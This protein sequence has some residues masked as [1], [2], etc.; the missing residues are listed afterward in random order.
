MGLLERFRRARPAAP[1]VTPE[2]SVHHAEPS[3]AEPAPAEPAPAEPPRVVLPPD[4]A[5]TMLLPVVRDL[6]EPPPALAERRGRH[7][8]PVLLP[9]TGP[10]PVAGPE[11][12]AAPAPT[13]PAPTEPAPPPSSGPGFAVVAVETT[14]LSPTWDRV[15]EVAVVRCDPSGAVEDAW[16]T[17]LDPGRRSAGTARRTGLRGD[18]LRGAPVFADVLGELADRLRG[19]V[20][21]AH[22]APVVTAF[23]REE[24][25][26][27]GW[28]LPPSPQLCTLRAGLDL[29]PPTGR[30]GVLDCAA[31]AALAVVPERSA[32]GGATAAAALLAALRHHPVAAS[33]FE[34]LVALAAD[35][36]WPPAP[37]VR[38][39]AV[40]R[41]PSGGLPPPT[42][43]GGPV[44][45]LAAGLVPTDVV[46]RACAPQPAPPH[47]AGYVE[48]L[49]GVLA[50]GMP[51]EVSAHGLREIAELSGLDRDQVQA[52]H[53]TALSDLAASA[54]ARGDLTRLTR[55]ELL[56]LGTVL[57]L[58]PAL[59]RST[60][61]EAEASLAR[62]TAAR[63]A[64][65]RST[66]AREAAAR[67]AAAREAAAREAAAREAAARE[68]EEAPQPRLQ[69]V[70]A[71]LL[72]PG[73]RVVF[74]LGDAVERGRLQ[75]RAR[76]AGL[77][78]AE[79]VNG[80]TDALVVD[81]AGARTAKA[82]TAARLGVRE[83]S[84]QDLAGVL[85][86]L[87]PVASG[88]GPVV[89]AAAGQW[90]AAVR[91]WA[92]ANGYPVGDRGRLPA[93]VL[94]A[95]HAAQGGAASPPRRAGAAGD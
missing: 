74:A 11:E 38:A 5:P 20:L 15:V 75:R 28:P 4:E 69:V 64:A 56:A 25:S 63:E 29:L 57:G 27:A 31:A 12:A 1:E 88:G 34:H 22:H 89:P 6:G 95:Y 87:G 82:A 48:V 26:R 65:A 66:A 43:E 80:M 10:A 36:S 40:P 84:P 9:E 90:A 49:A 62:S 92:R 21:V 3:P 33:A 60:V 39:V 37:A 8:A 93:A 46:A 59:V 78:V 42:G 17:L 52:L 83:L 67:E 47:A 71:P 23:L 81:G 16:T 2:L 61:E 19:R 13:E 7:R 18:D 44:A 32:L 45:G 24:A 94:E 77:V 51:S 76:A 54:C 30:R 41:T 91:A 73:D 58:G 55:A 68:A 85:E 53:A 50:D 35:T 79:V 14:G 72:V 86:H 70:E